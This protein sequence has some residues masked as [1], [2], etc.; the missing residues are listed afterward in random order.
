VENPTAVERVAIAANP[1]K[2]DRAIAADLGIGKDTVRRAR[3]EGG[4]E[5]LRFQC[6]PDASQGA[7]S[8]MLNPIKLL[9][10]LRY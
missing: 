1:Q 9:R 4:S 8:G 2:S 7:F 5:A 6:I 3:E 10:Y